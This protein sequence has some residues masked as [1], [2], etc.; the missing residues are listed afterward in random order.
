V[1]WKSFRTVLSSIY[2]LQTT[3]FCVPQLTNAEPLEAAR[4]GGFVRAS[5]MDSSHTK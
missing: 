2:Q 3:L 1:V 5:A 4:N